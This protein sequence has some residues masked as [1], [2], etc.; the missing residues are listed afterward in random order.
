MRY[1]ATK[2]AALTEVQTTFHWEVIFTGPPFSALAEPLAMRMTSA[3]LPKAVHNGLE[4]KAHGHKFP[5]PGSVDRSGE[6]TLTAFE[7]VGAE[8]IKPVREW[9]SNIWGTESGDV[10]GIQKVA[11][12]QLF[13][14]VTINLLNKQENKVT[15]T[16]TLERAILG[17]FDQGGALQDGQDEI[18]YFKP[19]I[20]L[21]FA[22][23]NWGQQG[24]KNL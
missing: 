17:D 24:Q 12:E 1:S 8:I 5:G 11:H 20:T 18:D 6:I 10:S 14:T 22:W 4:V 7:S 3:D 19:V 13:G 16:Y 15:Q 21:R 2:L 9:Y 23:F